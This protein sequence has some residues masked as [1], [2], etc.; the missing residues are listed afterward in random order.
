MVSWGD[1]RE[2]LPRETPKA[3]SFLEWDANGVC[4]FMVGP[5][6]RVR[7]GAAF[8][9]GGE[10]VYV[11]LRREQP[12]HD[13]DAPSDSEIARVLAQL[14]ARSPFGE[15]VRASGEARTRF[16]RTTVGAQVARRG[17]P[18]DAHAPL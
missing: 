3:W 7:V 9:N 13:D 4:T 5:R 18:T 12:V 2:F 16:F 10:H 8:A 17:G 11:M 1:A 6:L 14:T 15:V